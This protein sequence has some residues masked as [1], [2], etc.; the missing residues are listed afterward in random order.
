LTAVDCFTFLEVQNGDITLKYKGQGRGASLD[1]TLG[2]IGPYLLG[3]FALYQQE[4]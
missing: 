4:Q 3:A 2:E 1:F